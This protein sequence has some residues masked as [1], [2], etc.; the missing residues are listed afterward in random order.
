MYA[1]IE[2]GGKQYKVA[3]GDKL[4]VEKLPAAKGATVQFDRVLMLAQEGGE[5][6]V[7]AQVVAGADCGAV[8]DATVLS[9]GRGDKI[10]VFKMKR[11][12]GYRRTQGHR[13]PYTDIRITA[14]GMA[15]DSAVDE[16]PAATETESK[17]RAPRRRWFSLSSN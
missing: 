9:H 11:R 2:T 12:K 13:Q 17:R 6:G 16:T 3:V 7:G 14:I 5:G 10:R 8:V 4:K 15:G 1:I